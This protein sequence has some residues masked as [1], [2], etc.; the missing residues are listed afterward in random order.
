MTVLIVEPDSQEAD[1]LA[2]GLSAEGFTCEWTED[3]TEA[4]R[5][6]PSMGALV[7]ESTL[8]GLSGLD[9]VRSLREH[10]LSVPVIFHAAR[11][12]PDDRVRGLEAGAD[13]FLSKPCTIPELAARIRAVLR[14]R[15]PA[16]R[17]ARIRVADLLWE[18]AL[19]RVSRSGHRIDL[20]PKEYA[21]VALL[22]DHR[23]EVVSRELIAQALWC[24][25]PGHV[26]IRST[27]A[28][29]VQIRRLRAKL[30][31]PF[32]TPLLHT[33]RG[34]GLVIESREDAFP[35]KASDGAPRHET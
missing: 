31:G 10:H 22:L 19:R 8:P 34:L 33:L 6:A 2:V 32:A 23:G 4:L 18:P 21:L 9:V 7:M 28:M 14:R 13:H 20:T 15:Q 29:D 11:C 5:R 25:S 30:D 16:S 12:S 1:R 35:R 24:Q 17:L 26:E 3:G 27:N